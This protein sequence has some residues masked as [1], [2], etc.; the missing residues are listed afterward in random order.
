MYLRHEI[1]VF[2]AAL[3]NYSESTPSSGDSKIR[4]KTIW[5]SGLHMHALKLSLKFCA[6]LLEQED[7]FTSMTPT[8][9]SS[10]FTRLIMGSTPIRLALAALTVT[11]ESALSLFRLKIV[12]S[13]I[14]YTYTPNHTIRMISFP[15]SIHALAFAYISFRNFTLRSSRL[16]PSFFKQSSSLSLYLCT[17]ETNT[18]LCAL[19]PNHFKHFDPVYCSYLLV[20]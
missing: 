4:N 6:E 9:L 10:D 17:A 13:H 3:S 15:S 8:L 12:L 2:S 11:L 16:Y 20:H 14:L 7:F 5:H 1:Y 18:L 19:C